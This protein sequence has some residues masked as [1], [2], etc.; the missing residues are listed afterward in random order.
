MGEVNNQAYSCIIFIVFVRRVTGATFDK[1]SLG[2]MG[3]SW[4]KFTG[5]CGNT[6]YV[7]CIYGLMFL[8]ILSLS[9][10][11]FWYRADTYIIALHIMEVRFGSLVRMKYLR[12]GREMDGKGNKLE[13]EWGACIIAQ[14]VYS[15]FDDWIREGCGGWMWWQGS[16]DG[17]IGK[18]K[19]KANMNDK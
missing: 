7:F 18:A 15:W 10:F 4:E 12:D 14:F 11:T 17:W 8:S 1:F 16:R 3:W 2:H 19:T 13:R 5:C 9:F 6:G